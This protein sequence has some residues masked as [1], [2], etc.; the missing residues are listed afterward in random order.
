MSHPTRGAAECQPN[1][2]P[3]LES[4]GAALADWEQ[5]SPLHQGSGTAGASKGTRSPSGDRVSVLRP[6]GEVCD[7]GV[8]RK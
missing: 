7:L 6:L 8:L 4:E 3:T 5:H 2:S 1:G